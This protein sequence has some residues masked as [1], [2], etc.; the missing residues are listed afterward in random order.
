MRRLNRMPAG[1]MRMRTHGSGHHDRL[2][3]FR[4]VLVG[5]RNLQFNGVIRLR[6]ISTP[7]PERSVRKNKPARL[8]K[9]R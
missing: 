1:E 4:I 2:A 7:V 6:H 5:I 3:G 9:N 8:R